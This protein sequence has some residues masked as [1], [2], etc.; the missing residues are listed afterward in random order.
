MVGP[1]AERDL[2]EIILIP[3]IGM[4]RKALE[5]I[6]IIAVCAAITFDDNGSDDRTGAD[7]TE[8]T[9]FASRHFIRSSGKVVLP[10]RWP[11]ILS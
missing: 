7:G 9:G 6:P 3:L 2:G 5:K 11:N 10:E 1:P 8:R 4:L